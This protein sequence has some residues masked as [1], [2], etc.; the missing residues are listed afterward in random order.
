MTA[1][2]CQACSQATTPRCCNT[3]AER[4]PPGPGQRPAAVAVHS[5]PRRCHRAVRCRRAAHRGPTAFGILHPGQRR[6]TEVGAPTPRTLGDQRGQNPPPAG[7]VRLTCLAANATICPVSLC[8][9]RDPAGPAP[10]PPGR[11]RPL[12]QR[13]LVERRRENRMPPQ[14]GSPAPVHPHPA[15][16]L[17]LH[18]NQVPAHRRTPRNRTARA[19]PPARVQAAIGPQRRYLRILSRLAIS[20]SRITVM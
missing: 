3:P 20:A 14:S 5:G 10:A 7:R 16:H 19:N 18:C 15:H 6:S 9:A 1:T 8:A 11:A 13:R 12:P 4:H 2:G 17:V